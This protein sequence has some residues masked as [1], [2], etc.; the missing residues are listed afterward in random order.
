MLAGVRD[1]AA[2]GIASLPSQNLY[3]DGENG[4]TI[5]KEVTMLCTQQQVLCKQI[6][7]VMEARCM[8]MQKAVLVRWLG[9]VS[10]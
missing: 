6:K 10:R 5:N 8:V 1:R 9:K 4:Q 2:N 7:Q 3:F